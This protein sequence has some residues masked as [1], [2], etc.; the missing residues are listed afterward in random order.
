MLA[1][2]V[3]IAK[4]MTLGLG[5]HADSLSW[6]SIVEMIILTLVVDTFYILSLVC[7][8]LSLLLLYYRVFRFGYFKKAGFAIGALCSAWG[9]IV[10]ILS[11]TSCS[12]AR[13]LWTPSLP[14]HCG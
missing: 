4:A 13:K 11:F 12:P 3:A 5:L 6:D 7:S 1:T 9:V 14:G 10:V 2:V 8:K